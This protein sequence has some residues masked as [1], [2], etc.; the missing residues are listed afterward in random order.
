[1]ENILNYLCVRNKF[2]VP[3]NNKFD[4]E[5]ELAATLISKSS[6]TK[7]ENTNK[8]MINK[9]HVCSQIKKIKS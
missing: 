2:Y 9:E 5:K 6:E 3:N 4:V 1:M 8:F 7:T